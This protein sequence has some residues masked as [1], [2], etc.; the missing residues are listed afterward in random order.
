MVQDE[1]TNASH[2]ARTR[3]LPEHIPFIVTQ[4]YIA[5]IIDAWQQPAVT[6]FREVHNILIRYVKQLVSTH[7]MQY[8]Q[9][10]SRI[11]YVR[12]HVMK[13]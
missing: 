4:Q 10:L 12:Y 11:T 5:S 13:D 3:E 8:P 7:F 6:I 9:L 2:R 1:E